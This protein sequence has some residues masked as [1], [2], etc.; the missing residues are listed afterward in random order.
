METVV[1]CRIILETPPPG[2]DYGP[3]KGRG[4]AYDPLE[5]WPRMNL[6]A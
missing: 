4:S 2:V 1:N 5:V 3:Q 6:Q